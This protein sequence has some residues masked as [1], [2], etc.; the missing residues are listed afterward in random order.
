MRQTFDCRRP[1]PTKQPCVALAGW[2]WAKGWTVNLCFNAW[3]FQFALHIHSRHQ[4]NLRVAE[5]PA[6][7]CYPWPL[8][9]NLRND[10]R[11]LSKLT[12]RPLAITAVSFSQ[13]P[14][15]VPVDYGSRGNAEC[16]YSRRQRLCHI[17]G[18][19]YQQGTRYQVLVFPRLVH[20][21]CLHNEW[22]S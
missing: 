18:L 2:Y 21:P 15:I 14:T 5:T 20:V 3:V 6:G 16:E 9:V 7:Q 8:S 10:R 19:S 4:Q 13:S 11:V 17:F 1:T 12:G 22:R